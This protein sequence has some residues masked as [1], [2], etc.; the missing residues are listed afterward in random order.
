M[1]FG[2]PADT[3]DQFFQSETRLFFFLFN[4]GE[5]DTNLVF[6]FIFKDCK[7]KKPTETPKFI[8]TELRGVVFF[9][10]NK[11]WILGDTN[12]SIF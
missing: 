11:V 9:Y 8:F 4:F 6:K 7:R 2:C 5:A 10:G 1:L 3:L 12:N